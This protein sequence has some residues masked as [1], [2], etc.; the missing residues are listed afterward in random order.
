MA[1]TPI[2]D[3]LAMR[4]LKYG[5][6]P[7]AERERVAA[8]LRAAGRRTEALLLYEGRAD[9]AS[10]RAERDHAIA[11]GRV[12]PLQTLLRLGA[13]V[14]ADHLRACAAAA[15]KHGRWMDARTCYRLLEDEASVRRIAEHLPKSLVPP[16]PPEPPAAP[17][18]KDA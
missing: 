15:E 17:P 8:L 16:P 6:A 14:T 12:F 10:L 1:R 4:E 11:H 9:H 3:A 18:A 7:E 5:E 13:E 2:P